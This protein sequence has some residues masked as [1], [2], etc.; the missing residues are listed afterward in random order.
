MLGEVGNTQLAFKS[1]KYEPGHLKKKSGRN[2][3][4]HVDWFLHS[5]FPGLH[6]HALVGMVT[7]KGNFPPACH[8]LLF[9]FILLWIH[10]FNSFLKVKNQFDPV[11]VFGPRMLLE[12]ENM[13]TKR[14]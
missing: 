6:S 4:V 11:C 1:N 8:L 2:V 12:L 14:L 5:P 13:D 7:G 10:F 9:P 3:E